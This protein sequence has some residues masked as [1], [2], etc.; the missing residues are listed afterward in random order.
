MQSRCVKII[1]KYNPRS[2]M[3]RISTEK[4]IG[5]I[6]V[7]TVTFIDLVLSRITIYR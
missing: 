3:K 5:S 4:H 7:F 1:A 6:I 2:F